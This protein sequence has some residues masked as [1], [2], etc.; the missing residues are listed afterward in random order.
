MTEETAVASGVRWTVPAMEMPTVLSSFVFL[1][2]FSVD[3][4]LLFERLEVGYCKE[5]NC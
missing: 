3:V 1:Q 2:R 4:C 5:N